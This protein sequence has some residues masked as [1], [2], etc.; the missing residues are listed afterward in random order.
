M[1][2]FK[3]ERKSD[4]VDDSGIAI[5]VQEVSAAQADADVPVAK[6]RTPHPLVN[7]RKVINYMVYHYLVDHGYLET[8]EVF[9]RENGALVPDHL[10]PDGKDVILYL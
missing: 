6:A 1:A 2:D 3:P 4:L 5:D 9:V 7:E 8:A 10:A